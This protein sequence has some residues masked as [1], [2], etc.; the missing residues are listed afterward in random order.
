MSSF[1]RLDT[2]TCGQIWGMR[3]AGASRD[4]IADAMH[5]KDGTKLSL[6][7]V[8]GVLAKKRELPK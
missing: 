4:Q 6:R 5:K 7:A 8:D 3:Q 2:F 1:A